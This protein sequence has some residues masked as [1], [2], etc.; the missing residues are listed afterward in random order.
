M[1]VCL[2]VVG[3]PKY[4]CVLQGGM[5]LAGLVLL[6]KLLLKVILLLECCGVEHNRCDC[7]QLLTLPILHP[8]WGWVSEVLE[9]RVCVMSTCA[10]AATCCAWAWHA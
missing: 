2:S 8:A 4:K 5:V 6:P 9:M 3:Q 1:V 10:G 7:V